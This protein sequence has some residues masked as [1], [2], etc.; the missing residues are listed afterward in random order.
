M[1]EGDEEEAKL[2]SNSKHSETKRLKTLWRTSHLTEAPSAGVPIFRGRA[3]V[4][5]KED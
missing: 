1:G 2:R 5:L 3:L 4:N